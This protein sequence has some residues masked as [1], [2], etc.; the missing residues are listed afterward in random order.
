MEASS[1]EEFANIDDLLG[2]D[3]D[4]DEE[5]DTKEEVKEET[6]TDDKGVIDQFVTEEQEADICDESF[7]NTD[8][9]D[10]EPE[11]DKKPVKPGVFCSDMLEDVLEKDSELSET[12]VV[13]KSLAWKGFLEKSLEESEMI[14]EQLEKNEEGIKAGLG[15]KKKTEQK[16]RMGRMMGAGEDISSNRAKTL[17]EKRTKLREDILKYGVAAI[18][19]LYPRQGQH[20]SRVKTGGSGGRKSGSRNMT[21]KLKPAPHDPTVGEIEAWKILRPYS[22]DKYIKQPESSQTVF[23]QRKHGLVPLS[24]LCRQSKTSIPS[25]VHLLKRRNHNLG[26][27]AHFIKDGNRLLGVGGTRNKFSVNI[28]IHALPTFEKFKPKM[29]PFVMDAEFANIAVLALKNNHQPKIDIRQLKRNKTLEDKEAVSKLEDKSLLDKMLFKMKHAEDS[30]E[31][32]GDDFSSMMESYKEKRK[33]KTTEDKPE[34]DDQEEEFKSFN[35]GFKDKDYIKNIDIDISADDVTKEDDVETENNIQKDDQETP[36][37]EDHNQESLPIVTNQWLTAPKNVVPTDLNLDE[38]PPL[39]G[40]KEG[41][42]RNLVPKPIKVNFDGFTGYDWCDVDDCYCRESEPRLDDSHQS[43]P[44]KSGSQTPSSGSKDKPQRIAKDLQRV[45]RALKTLGVNIIEFDEHDDQGECMKDYCKL[46][47]ICDSLRTKQIPPMHCGK[48]DCMF[49]CC[50]SK[51]SLKYSS[52][53]GSRRVNISAAVGARIMED[54]QRGMAAEEKKFSNTVVVTADNDT[55]MLGGRSTR[56]ERKVPERYKNSNTLMLDTA[57][58]DYV[59]KTASSESDDDIENESDDDD[60]DKL[61]RK[62]GADLIPCTVIMPMVNLPTNTSIWCM[63]H[64]QYSCPCSK[65]KNPLDFAPDIESSDISVSRKDVMTPA[66]VIRKRSQDDESKQVTVKKS[67]MVGPK[68]KTHKSTDTEPLLG[69]E[70]IDPDYDKPAAPINNVRHPLSTLAVKSMKNV[71]SARTKPV[72]VKQ[73]FKTSVLIPPKRNVK[74]NSKIP[75]LVKIVGQEDEDYNDRLEISQELNLDISNVDAKQYIRWDILK[76]KFHCKEV[77][78]FFW[79]RPGR[80]RNMLFLTPAGDKPFIAT[81][82]S[83]RTIQVTNHYSVFC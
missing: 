53:C 3:I 59:Q 33:V 24:T 13:P 19:K 61:R 72:T 78:M 74:K 63:Y 34:P 44:G 2:G 65:Y 83:L 51:E 50:C 18:E 5:L 31:L 12:V 6:I 43:L 71:Q 60:Y 42:I 73:N 25:N 41:N 40:Y 8:D 1:S 11:L 62:A 32:V 21:F 80:G 70:D 23:I 47:C 38:C 52:S 10:P 37:D 55:V 48:V 35:L 9:H 49:S 4:E 22:H 17:A 82:I 16:M 58:K 36:T 75:D 68:S 28:K 14:S 64:A 45:K 56:R 15:Q 29:T 76:S 46:G 26:K 77:D 39:T 66:K 54:T 27:P 20:G 69:I 67:R 79:V 81:A 30:K 57:G 7:G